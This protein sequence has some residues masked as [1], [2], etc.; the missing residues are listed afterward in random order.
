MHVKVIGSNGKFFHFVLE[1]RC[2]TL[3]PSFSSG[4]ALGCPYSMGSN[5]PV[6]SVGSSMRI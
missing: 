6:A 5:A 4:L 1:L 2:P 3:N